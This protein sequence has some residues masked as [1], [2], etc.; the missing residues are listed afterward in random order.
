MSTGSTMKIL[1]IGEIVGKAGVYCVKTLLPKVREEHGIDLVIANGDGATGGFGIG[2]NHSVY[3]HKLGADVI[4]GGDQIY[5]KKD[6]VTHIATAPYILR[7]ANFPPGNPGR[8]WRVFTAGE[9]KVAV[10]SLLGQSGFGRVHLSNPFTFLPELVDRARKETDV[11]VVDFHAVTTAEKLTMFHLADGLVSAVIGTGQRVATA[12][13]TVRRN[14]TAT[15]CDAGRTGSMD[16]VSGLQIDIEVQKLIR[17]MPERSEE[18]WT[19]LALNGVILEL[20]DGAAARSIER[21]SVPCKEPEHDRESARS[22]S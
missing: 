15:I 9:R 3:L 1:F 8:G 21:I 12:D 10:I 6:M 14:G 17:Q 5:Y 11:V 7:A 13:E 22:A 16:G 19:N 4:T 20:A 2:K 18:C